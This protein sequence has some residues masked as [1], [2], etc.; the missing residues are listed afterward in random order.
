M[1]LQTSFDARHQPTSYS[2][3]TVPPAVDCPDVPREGRPAA[4]LRWM[5]GN[6]PFAVPFAGG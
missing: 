2:A 6:L 1:S 4:W 3:I 5:L